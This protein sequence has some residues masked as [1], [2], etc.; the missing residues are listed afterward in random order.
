M[1]RRI[2][3]TYDLKSDWVS[4][5]G[6]P[7]DASAEFDKVTTI[8]SVSNALES[9]GHTVVKIGNVHQLISVLDDLDVDIIFNICEGVRG[10][11]RESQVPAILE[12]KGIPFI[13]ADALTLGLTLDK[14]ISKKIFLADGIPTAKFWIINSVSDIDLLTDIQFPLFVKT[15]QEG[16]SKGVSSNSQVHNVEQLRKQVSFILKQYDQPVLAEAFISGCEFTVAVLGNENPQAMPAVQYAIDGQFDLGSKFYTYDMLVDESVEYVC[17]AKIDAKLEKRLQQLAVKVY[18]SVG[19]RDFGRV[20]FR[21]DDQGN[22]FVLEI[23]PLP[24]LETQDVFGIFPPT[25]GLTYE[26]VINNIVD[27]ALDRYGMNKGR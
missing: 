24:S 26:K 27:H 21:V 4:T 14:T 18:N 15:S 17:P 13:G 11:N 19:C 1:G 23:N 3:F 20:D 16:S 9:G 10:R 25:I 12:L 2:G 7:I 8:E 22:P 5:S 6:E